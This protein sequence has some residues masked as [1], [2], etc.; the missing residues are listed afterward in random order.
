[1][2]S[3]LRETFEAWKRDRAARLGAAI[4]YYT[5]VSLAPLLIIAVAIG[6][7]VFG[8]AAARGE[9]VEQIGMLIGEESARGIQTILEQAQQQPKSGLHAGLLGITVLLVGAAGVFIQLQDALNA[10]WR[11]RPKL[12]SAL[13]ETL[14]KYLVSFSMVIGIGFLL[15]VSLV[16]SA[17]LSGLSK[18]MGSLMPDN[19]LTVQWINQLLSLALITLLLAV[20]FKFVPDVKLAWRDVWGAAALT[21]LLFTIGK[22]FIGLY[23]GHSGISSAYG[24]AG[25]LVVI[26][27]WVY[28]S[29]QIML[30]G[31]E[32]TKCYKKRRGSQIV[33]EPHAERFV[34]KVRQPEPGKGD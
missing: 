33:A 4:A 14:Q 20:M 1:M 22:F 2:W 16:M 29:T 7:A 24:A 23:L 32:F 26:L 19:L 11:V 10:I 3:L 15:L 5:M 30:F 25:S 9:I 6:G 8:E 13:K 21:S 28:Y 31:V 34:R 17:M 18:Y 27:I 12:H